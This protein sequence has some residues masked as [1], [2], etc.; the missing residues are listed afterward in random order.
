[1]GLGLVGAGLLAAGAWGGVPSA[2]TPPSAV[3]IRPAVLRNFTADQA[4]LRRYRY[5][6]RVILVKGGS[7][8]DRTLSVYYVQGRSVAPEIALDGQP[9]GPRGRAAQQQAARERAAQL[10]HRPPPPLGVVDFR[11]HDYSFP[12]LAADFHY[13]PARVVIWH[14][15]TTWVYPAWPNPN[16]PH[17]SSAEKVLLA[18]RGTVWI[19]AKDLH[20]VRVQ[21]HTFRPVR[22]LAGIL[23]TVH[24]A[25]LDL[26]LQRVAPGVWLPAR[27]A[28]RL[29]ATLL[30]LKA[31]NESKVESYW[32]YHR[33][34]GPG[35]QAA[36]GT[37]SIVKGVN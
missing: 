36:D 27:T 11:G 8:T 13:G 25:T 23:A 35:P 7:R 3:A 18:S 16:A 33:G 22:Y 21:M 37:R 28:F 24:R 10:A 20:L 31:F 17:P 32:A 4:A 12:R 9:L 6:E 26:Q 34:T 1:M 29:R 2:P 14:G 5:R 19:D 30:L 15:R